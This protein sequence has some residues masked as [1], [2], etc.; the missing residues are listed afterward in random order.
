M[1][2]RR[3]QA[4]LREWQT[5][6]DDATAALKALP[7]D[8]A[9]VL[10]TAFA[11]P[12]WQIRLSKVMNDL[13]AAVG[14]TL[15]SIIDAPLPRD[16]SEQI[17]RLENSA[18]ELRAMLDAGTIESD[19]QTEPPANN[20]PAESLHLTDEDALIINYLREQHP[21]L[22]TLP[23]IE[24]GATVSRKTVG[25]RVAKLLANNI[26]SRPQGKNSGVGLTPRGLSLADTCG[27]QNTR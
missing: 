18:D 17:E 5:A 9:E 22:R 14:A 27:A 21:R 7:S 1:I 6:W 8:V 12:H 25:L 2:L 10:S 20:E 16:W 3:T 13:T 15:P 26:L 24:A 19:S 11:R 23:D 4:T